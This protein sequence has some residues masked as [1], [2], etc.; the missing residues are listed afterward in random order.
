MS[1]ADK[2]IWQYHLRVRH[3]WAEILIRK[4]GLFAAVS[5]YG[6]YA[7]WWTDT[8]G[9]DAR[10]FFA[11]AGDSLDTYYFLCKLAPK[12]HINAD[13]SIAALKVEILKRRRAREISQEEAQDI[14]ETVRA[15]SE[16]WHG[17]V[18]DTEIYHFFD[19]E[20]WH[21]AVV[22][23]DSDAVAFCEIFLP[24]LSRVIIEQLKAEKG[25]VHP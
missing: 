16:D 24:E 7:Y 1:K 6:K 14:Y 11:R 20:P 15:Y 2:R 13:K 3:E 12:E 18:R 8:G 9:P 23:H 4:D 17:A 25:Q 22:E 10:H 5:S 19:Q 21:Y